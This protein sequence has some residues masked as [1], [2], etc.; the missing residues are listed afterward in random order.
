MSYLVSTKGRYALR[1][2]LDLSQHPE[3]AVPLKE[4][5]DRQNISLKYLETIMPSLKEAGFVVGTHGKGGGYK[6]SRPADSYTVGEI[7][8]VTEGSISPVACLDKGYVCDRANECPTLPVWRKLDSLIKGYL[9]TVKLT[10]L[11]IEPTSGDYQ[12]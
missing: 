12:I 4:I 10:D 5:A 1:V 8:R 6:L 2:L 7:L 9:D 3:S 11:V